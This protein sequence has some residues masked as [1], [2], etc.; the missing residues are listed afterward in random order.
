MGQTIQ[1]SDVV[2]NSDRSDFFRLLPAADIPTVL[3]SL[4]ISAVLSALWFCFK[5]QGLT[6]LDED[7]EKQR[8]STFLV[9]PTLFK[10]RI[11]QIR[12]PH[13]ARP[14]NRHQCRVLST[15]SQGPLPLS[16]PVTRGSQVPWPKES[17]EIVCAVHSAPRHTSVI[18]RVFFKVNPCT[19]RSRCVK[20][21]GGREGP[22]W[23]G[24]GPC[25]RQTETRLGFD[26]HRLS[27]GALRGE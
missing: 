11:C 25:D 19:V 6:S 12:I 5:G 13:R 18:P 27:L 24:H 17:D 22:A 26:R 1:T 10:C 15:G 14:H 4:V 21:P 2:L 23:S 8:S 9:N 16:G 3:P 7:P 20:T